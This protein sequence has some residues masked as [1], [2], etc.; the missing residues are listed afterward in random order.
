MSPDTIDSWFIGL[1]VLLL[2]LLLWRILAA[3]PAKSHKIGPFHLPLGVSLKAQ[4]LL[5]DEQLRFYNLIRIA[6]EDRYLV[7]AQ[8]PLWRIISVEAEKN[9]QREVLRHLAL[10][11]VDFALVHP[12]SRVVE[13]VIQLDE[14][15]VSDSGDQVRRREVQRIVQAAG[16]RCTTLS[17]EP[18]YT[19]Q[20][21]QRLLEF[22]DFE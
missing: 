1:I 3:G 13:Q 10:K 18:T 9:L 5:T 11:R 17:P 15:P 22:S 8:V 20:E 19:V 4:A 21:L 12:G 2:A 14:E 7:F 16:I 6:V